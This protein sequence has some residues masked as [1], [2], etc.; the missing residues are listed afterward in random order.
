MNDVYNVDKITL[1]YIEETFKTIVSNATCR[2][3]SHDTFL[4]IIFL[5]LFLVTLFTCPLSPD[6]QLLEEKK[7]RYVLSFLSLL[8]E[9]K[10]FSRRWV[11]I[12][13]KIVLSLK[14]SF[15][16]QLEMS[17]ILM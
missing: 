12:S 2:G 11:I 7:N 15:Q 4:L 5:F 16:L 8:V 1:H 13:C 6:G 14:K 17:R 9:R 3:V 10:I